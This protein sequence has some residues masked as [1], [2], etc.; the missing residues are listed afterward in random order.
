MQFITFS[1]V[2]GSGKS[3]Q[4]Q[5]LKAKLEQEGKKVAYFHAVEFSL[6]TRLKKSIIEKKEAEKAI[7]EA[8]WFSILLRKILLGIDLFRFRFYMNALYQ[9]GYTH[10]LSD[11][12]FYDTIVNIEYLKAVNNQ[13]SAI[14]EKQDFLLTVICSLLPVPDIAF[15]FD[16][17]PETIMARERV[18]EQGIEYLREKMKLFKKKTTRWNMIIIDA[19]Q[20]QNSTSQNILKKLDNSTSV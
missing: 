14:S 7:T 5:L 16:L 17:T 18:P 8:S 1:G 11:R 2:D 12:Y 6:A 10:L 20:D 13:P 9:E 19:S 4:L 3:T 15:Y